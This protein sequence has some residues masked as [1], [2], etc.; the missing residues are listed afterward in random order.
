MPD[1]VEAIEA[2]IEKVINKNGPMTHNLCGMLLS[3]LA[4]IDKARADEIYQDLI[5]GGI[6]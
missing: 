6:L 2:E 1:T 4:T 5:D 3:R